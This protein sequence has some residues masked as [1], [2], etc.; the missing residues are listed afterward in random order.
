M[1]DGWGTEDTVS[2]R[3]VRRP[4]TRSPVRLGSPRSS[5]VPPAS[6][7]PV[8]IDGRDATTVT[9]RLSEK[10]R[11]LPTML[12]KTLTWE[13]G[14]ELAGHQEMTAATGSDVH[15]ADPRNPWQ[16]G[17]NE[18]TDRLLRQYLPE[19]TSMGHLSQ[20]DL[21]AIALKPN[22][23]PRGTLGFDTPADGAVAAS[24]RL[25]GLC[26]ELRRE[27]AART[28]LL[29]PHALHGGHP[30]GTRPLILDVRRSESSPVR[31]RG[32][33]VGAAVADRVGM[34]ARSGRLRVSGGV[35]GCEGAQ[36]RK[37]LGAGLH[38]ACLGA[39]GPLCVARPAVGQ[40]VSTPGA[41]RAKRRGTRRLEHSEGPAVPWR[42]F[43]V[44]GCPAFWSRTIRSRR[45]AA[46][47]GKGRPL[48]IGDRGV[49]KT[50]LPR[51]TGIG[52]LGTRSSQPTAR[53]RSV[54]VS[55][56]RGTSS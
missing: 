36:C 38:P 7:V 15:F 34:R 43:N 41:R 2:G 27:R 50:R 28:R 42:G 25:D 16:C 51:C 19:D 31:V 56:Q 49:P 20:D 48:Q 21:D 14:T 52:D 23:R 47:R 8:R 11:S 10:P 46:R 53:R 6:R 37:V 26:L 13:R 54:R 22:S 30:S 5:N 44:C 29:P 55:P 3:G 9:A 45:P 33:L 40:G 12:R 18:N 1:W 4:R 39:V 35:L 17:T 32:A 24:A